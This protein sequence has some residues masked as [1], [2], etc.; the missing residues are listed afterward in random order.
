MWVY[1]SP[2]A[3][4]EALAGRV[5]HHSK[6]TTGRKHSPISQVLSARVVETRVLPGRWVGLSVGMSVTSACHR[7]SRDLSSMHV[8]VAGV[9]LDA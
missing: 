3:A 8:Q 6:H 9:Q 2:E 5:L 4:D 7:Y 1:A